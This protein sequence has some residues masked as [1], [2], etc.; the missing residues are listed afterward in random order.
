MRL[1]ELYAKGGIVM[2]YPSFWKHSIGFILIFMIEGCSTFRCAPPPTDLYTKEAYT[3]EKYEADLA[4]YKHAINMKADGTRYRD[5]IVYSTAAEIDKN[6]NNFKNSFFGERAWTE[7]SFD[8]A[9]IGLGTFGALAGGET[10]N[11]LAAIS[12]GVAGTRLS[13]NKNFFKERSSDLLLSRM[14]AL[15]AEKWAEICLKLV[16]SDSIYS[17]REAERDLV[18]YYQRGSLQAAFQNITAESGAAQKE[19]DNE[20]KNQIQAKYGP[21]I[22][23]LASPNNTEEIDELYNNFLRLKIP[24][25]ENQ[26]KMIVEDFYKSQPGFCKNPLPDQAKIDDLA[27][28]MS[29]ARQTDHTNEE[30]KSLAS[31]FIN[32]SNNNSD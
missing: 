21:L 22:E 13:F 8:I 31:A 10:V 15:R 19:A 25:Q 2:R 17:L 23:P 26:A 5:A 30:R 29:L 12:T 14:D 32:A 9:Q 11:L 7:T 27:F 1:P 4:L 28:I 24:E 6:Y 20:I 18:E 3:P 16:K